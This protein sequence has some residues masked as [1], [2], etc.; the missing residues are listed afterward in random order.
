MERRSR[1]P[2]SRHRQQSASHRAHRRAPAPSNRQLKQRLRIAGAMLAVAL[3][4]PAVRLVQLQ[5]VQRRFWRERAGV[6]QHLPVTIP[7]FR[8]TIVDRHPVSSPDSEILAIDRPTYQLWSRPSLYEYEEGQQRPQE[9]LAT[10]LAPIFDAPADEL[11]ELLEQ[12]QSTLIRQR[13]SESEAQRVRT[14]IFQA[15]AHERMNLSGWELT[16]SRERLYPQGEEAAEVVGYIQ[17]DSERRGQAGVEMSAQDLLELAPEDVVSVMS[18]GYGQPLA[19]G[20]PPHALQTDEQVLQLTLDMRLQRAAREALRQGVST[21]N[22]ERGTAIALD[23]HTGEILAMASEPT[24][25]P[26]RFYEYFSSEEDY[27]LFRNWAVSD[28]YEPGSTF[29]PL[30]VAL[31][32]ESGAILPDTH[33]HDVGSLIVD[34]WPIHNYD[35][36]STAVEP[37]WMSISEVLQRSSNIG[38]IRI[39]DLLGRDTLHSGLLDLGLNGRSGVDLPFEP[40]SYMKRRW[41]FLL[42][43]V[44]AA[45]TSFGQGIAMTPLQLAQLHS[46]I[47]NGGYRVTPHV[48]RGLVDLDSNELEAISRSGRERVLSPATTEIVR[49]MMLDVVEAGAG[50]PAAIPGYQIAGKTGTAQKADPNGGGYL[51]SSEQITS[52]VGYFPA[53]DPQYVILVV[54]DNPRGDNVFGSTVAAPI[55]RAIVEEIVAG[56]MLRPQ[57]QIAAG[58]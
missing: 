55:V 7:N 11:L 13:L 33:V 49:G 43:R 35:Y 32:L 20:M 9:V 42:S 3:V 45:T 4:A 39:V 22:A 51:P 23:P 52:F 18:D 36:T 14:E 16:P 34:G 54:V 24:Y 48:V 25:D 8:R 10:V 27:R 2:H 50:S 19:D 56:D 53:L 12:P 46:T 44:E 17:L 6:Q 1:S 29:K 41:Q 38:M 37:G 21:F 30:T 5:V 26:N 58:E 40:N 28:L 47:A 15:M 31:A 57:T